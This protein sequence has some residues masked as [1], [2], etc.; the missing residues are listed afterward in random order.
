[1]TVVPC[2][3]MHTTSPGRIPRAPP[4]VKYSPFQ[5]DDVISVVLYIQKF[6]PEPRPER[7]VAVLD[8]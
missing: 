1:M 6:W 8:C 5:G 7:T 2:C 3:T 4:S